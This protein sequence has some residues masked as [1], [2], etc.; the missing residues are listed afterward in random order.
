MAV[1]EETGGI[2][3]SESGA[4]K[5]PAVRPYQWSDRRQRFFA[6]LRRRIV[7][8]IGEQFRWA[9]SNSVSGAKHTSS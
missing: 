3:V 1:T 6:C 2:C 9:V 5:L 8:A 4:K 7:Y